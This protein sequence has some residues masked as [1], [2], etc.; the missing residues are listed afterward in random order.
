MWYLK[1]S[2]PVSKMDKKKK[3]LQLSC[4]VANVHSSLN[5]SF[6]LFCFKPTKPQS[7]Q[8]SLSLVRYFWQKGP[9]KTRDPQC[10]WNNWEGLPGPSSSEDVA[11]ELPA[12][13]TPASAGRQPYVTGVL[14]SPFSCFPFLPQCQKGSDRKLRCPQYPP[15]G[16]PLPFSPPLPA[17]CCCP[18]NSVLL[19]CS[20]QT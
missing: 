10:G 2:P 12:A 16:V 13:R 14:Q 8:A 4:Q 9:Y 15:Y 3:P 6:V 18:C 20:W 7:I 19:G 1:F 5:L 17:A 11:L